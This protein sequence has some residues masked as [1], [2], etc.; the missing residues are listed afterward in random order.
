MKVL[1]LMK[2]SNHKDEDLQSKLDVFSIKEVS[3]VVH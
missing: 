1:R 3:C 2:S